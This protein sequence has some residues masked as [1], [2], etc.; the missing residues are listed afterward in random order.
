MKLLCG[1][2]N[3]PHYG[4]CPSVRLPGVSM[5]CGQYVCICISMDTSDVTNGVLSDSAISAAT[6]NYNCPVVVSGFAI[7][8]CYVV[9][10]GLQ[11]PCNQPALR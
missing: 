4:S 2:F 1:H 5:D 11:A 10:V 8:P 3:R 9:C 7:A 6:I